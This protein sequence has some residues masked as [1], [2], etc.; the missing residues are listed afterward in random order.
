MPNSAGLLSHPADSGGTTSAVS[1]LQ[2]YETNETE[3]CSYLRILFLHLKHYSN[4]QPLN[5]TNLSY[6]VPLALGIPAEKKH[7]KPHQETY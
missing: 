4:Q 5:K 7:I 3:A 2:T 1:H 6:K